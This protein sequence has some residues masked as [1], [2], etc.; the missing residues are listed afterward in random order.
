MLPS[1]V[2]SIV[3]PQAVICRIRSV[4]SFWLSLSVCPSLHPHAD[5]LA[6]MSCTWQS[7]RTAAPSHTWD[8]LGALHFTCFPVSLWLQ[9]RAGNLTAIWKLVLFSCHLCLRFFWWWSSQSK[10]WW[11]YVLSFLFYNMSQYTEAQNNLYDLLAFSF[12][13]PSPC[14]PFLRRQWSMFPENGSVGTVAAVLKA[15]VWRVRH[16]SGQCSFALFMASS[17]CTKLASSV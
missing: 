9:F 6:Y 16:R 5:V 11:T 2:C 14:P 1:L 4:V 12:I 8:I 10:W 3:L 17:L 15:V 13:L 7:V